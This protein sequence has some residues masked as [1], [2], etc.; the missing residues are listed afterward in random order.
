MK[1]SKSH[2]VISLVLSLFVFLSTLSVT[3]EKHFC[4]DTLVDVAVFSKVKK[5]CGDNS[6]S[7]DEITQNSCCKNETDLVEGLR[8][9]TVKTFDDLD[10]D[11]QKVLLA[12]TYAYVS[13][14]ESLPKKIVPHRDYSPPLLI[15][16]IQ[17]LDETYLI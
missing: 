11:K 2:K 9:L 10:L 5:C 4:G 17:V 14:Y 6:S 1:Y 8:D 12:F 16:D 7:S 3:I 13:L 15:K